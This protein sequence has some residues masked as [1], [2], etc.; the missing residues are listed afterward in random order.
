ML[1]LLKG[2]SSAAEW[3]TGTARVHLKRKL[4]PLQI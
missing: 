3:Y 2:N 1:T 4:W